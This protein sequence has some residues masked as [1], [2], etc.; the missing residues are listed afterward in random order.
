MESFFEF[1][2]IIDLENKENNLKVLELIRKGEYLKKPKCG[3]FWDDFINL[4]S[5]LD[6]VSILF[7]V[8]KEKV[9]KWSQNINNLRE[10][11]KNEDNSRLS[12][13]KVLKTGE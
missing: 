7:D 12:K 6:A 1:L 3:N 4:C 11:I 5:N 2:E 10:Y 9:S 8:P 13:N